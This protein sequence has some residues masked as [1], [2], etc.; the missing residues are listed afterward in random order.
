[1]KKL[2]EANLE[3]VGMSL[4]GPSIAI[5]TARDKKNVRENPQARWTDNCDCDNG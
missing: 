5:V 4:V 2:P 1:M 3:F